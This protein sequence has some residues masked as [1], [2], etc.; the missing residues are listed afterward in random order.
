MNVKSIITV[1]AILIIPLVAFFGLTFHKDT[2]S[3]VAQAKGKPQKTKLLI[4][5]LLLITATI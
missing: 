1:L 2:S 4:Q 5:K 3:I